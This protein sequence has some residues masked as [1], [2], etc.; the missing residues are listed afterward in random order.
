M[1][2][3]TGWKVGDIVRADANGHENIWLRQAVTFTVDGQ[4]RTLEIGIPLPPGATRD[5]VEALLN[6]A[7]AGMARLSRY[8]DERVAAQLGTP[9]PPPAP[10][11]APT[12][13][14]T[15]QAPV[16][17]DEAIAEAV[18]DVPELPATPKPVVEEPVAAST[19]PSRSPERE[20]VAPA[21][22]APVRSVPRPSSAASPQAQ[23]TAAPAPRTSR[24]TPPPPATGPDMTR[25]QFIA[26]LA[27]LGLNPKQAMDRLG[28]RSL[29]GLNLRE[30]LEVLRRQLVQESPSAP[31]A[32]PESEASA[33]APEPEA[34]PT[35]P[36]PRYFDEEDDPD[37]VFTVDAPDF[38]DEEA[39]DTADAASV[40]LDDEDDLDL[41]D[42]PD[43]PAP[44]RAAVPSAPRATRKPAPTS[45]PQPAPADASQHEATGS[46]R[47]RAMQLVGKLRSAQ[48]GG[49]ASDYQRKAYHNLVEGQLDA[50]QA[51][52][53]VRGLWRIP[54]ARL[55]SDQLDALIR[56]GKEDDFVDEAALVLATLRAE[57]ARAASANGAADAQAPATP[58]QRPR[59]AR[60]AGASSSARQGS[61]R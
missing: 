58:P 36:E 31:A 40:P 20:P 38:E 23:P 5:D 18:A 50:D 60:G 59:P 15:E 33:P 10:I 41:E 24:P 6:Q 43:F 2:G 13:I 45:T 47:A 61:A 3:R 1:W 30:A 28:V 53:L 16:S 51:A 12:P 52:A 9:L 14:V 32:A 8:L 11:I 56:W 49:P 22:P 46:E 57:Q 17:A 35:A 7:D 21:R 48:G 26:A 4:T 29:E 19:P 27:E 39:L 55:T 54:P 25:P 37:L 34:A 44:P 42:V